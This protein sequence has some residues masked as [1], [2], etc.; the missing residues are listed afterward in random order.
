VAEDLYRVKPYV[1]NAPD[2]SAVIV[3]TGYLSNLQELSRRAPH[4]SNSPRSPHNN[5]AHASSHASALPTASSL[6][7][8]C[9]IERSLD[10]GALT[11]SVVLGLYQEQKEGGELIMLSELQVG[12]GVVW[13]PVTGRGMCRVVGNACLHVPCPI[14]PAPVLP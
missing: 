4:R 7:R 2:D 1:Y 9:S 14:A 13:W 6:E 12:G 3:F 5:H 11:A 10:I 8:R